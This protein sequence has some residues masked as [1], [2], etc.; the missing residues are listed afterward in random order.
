MAG[1][2]WHHVGS[3]AWMISTAAIGLGFV[4]FVHELGHFVV[5]K[6]CGVKCEKFYI[7]FDFPLSIGPLRLPSRLYHVQWGE[8]EYGIGILPLGGYVKMLGQDDNPANAQREAERIRV[9]KASSGSE[10]DAT[11]AAV[12]EQSGESAL[13]P[14]SYPAKR[15]P[16]RMAII[17]AGVVM[18]LIFAVIFAA[19]AFNAGVPYTP[20]EVGGT[21]PGSPAWRHG[22]MP[23]D[24]IVQL[25]ESSRKSDHLRFDWD[26]RNAVGMAGDREDLQLVVLKS[27]GKEEAVSLRPMVTRIEG[28]ELPMLG[29]EP[30]TTTQLAPKTP[31]IPGYSAT[32]ATPALKG[33]DRILAVNGEQIQ[34]RV[35][36][37]RI[38]AAQSDKPLTL[39]VERAADPNSSAQPQQVTTTVPVNYAKRIGLVLTPAPISGVQPD[40][41]AKRAGLREGDQLIS[42]AGEPIG[43]PLT[44][45]NR[46]QAHYGKE[47]EIKVLRSVNG[48]K[49]EQLL[50]I[51]PEP[52]NS[53][54]NTFTL[55]SPMAVR[56]LGIV[57]PLIPRVAEV[58]KGAPAEKAGLQV[59]DEITTVAFASDDPKRKPNE[60]INQGK[61]F[62]INEVF[63]WPFVFDRLQS[64]ESD[65]TLVLEYRRG[66]QLATVRLKPAVTTE[67]YADRGFV[68]APLT[69][70]RTAES[71]SEAIVLG[72]RQT[73]EDVSRVFSFLKKLVSGS[74]SPKNLGGPMSIA[75]VA[76][77][78]ASQG[79]SRLLMFLTFL[80]ANLAVLNF[81][82]IPALDG[83]HMVFLL[84]E[85]IRGKPVDERMQVALT[86]A[87]V[88]C[89]LGL[90]IFVFA[91]DIGRF[92]L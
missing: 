3:V 55:G 44:L 19:L 61:P 66:S 22:F 26:L 50:R 79:I 56:S 62:G 82:P 72:L 8:T 60:L 23:G 42:I 20:C 49:S 57:F 35:Q 70:T 78:E 77:A 27:N 10:G 11:A 7:G 16:L 17:S 13:D 48:T 43:D 33:G 32:R 28:D 47:T 46:L 21:V 67:P 74:I 64:F 59:G 87:G 18:N 80:S 76:G 38:L 71:W 40:S 81:L 34:N 88:A 91:L 24:R 86:L 65:D 51:T 37:S 73:S 85:G 1:I 52:P 9:P 14:R 54:E 36:L 30:A 69:E 12:P 92:F 4:I 75:A 68:F 41:P 29:I 45:T 89:L 83:G 58:Q 6:L 63:T 90:M 84:A 15:V 25:G 39:I 53:Y 5:A 2:D 31:A